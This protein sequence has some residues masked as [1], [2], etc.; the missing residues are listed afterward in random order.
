[1]TIEEIVCGESRN[2]ELKEMLPKDS[3]KYTKTIIA[4][5]NSQG[6]QLIIGVEDETRKITGVDKDSVFQIMDSIANAVSDSCTPQIV[7]DISFQTIEGRTV[8]AVSVAPGVNRPYYL[9]SK[10]KEKG[11]YV[12]VAGTS[13]LAD[14]EKIKELEY[15]GERISWDEQICIGCPVT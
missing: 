4:F 6:G 14:A 13:R 15:E 1:M 8:V 3:E 7:P 10:G 12:R 5:A 9:K 2:T 11:T